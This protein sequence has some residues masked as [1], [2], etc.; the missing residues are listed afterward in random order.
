MLNI[1]DF[2]ALQKLSSVL[3]LVSPPRISFDTM[4]SKKN[5]IN[6]LSQAVSFSDIKYDAHEDFR[7]SMVIFSNFAAQF[8]LI[9]SLFL[10]FSLKTI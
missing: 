1:T 3:R 6:N 5:C 7:W 8:W 9:Y 10:A 2:N 4:V